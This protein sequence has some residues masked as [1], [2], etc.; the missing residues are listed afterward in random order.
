MA[1]LCY[2]R[3]RFPAE[4]IQHPLAGAE[5]VE[6]ITRTAKADAFGPRLRFVADSPLEG[7]GFEPSVPLEVLTVVIVPCRLRGPFHA[8]KF[9]ADSALEERFEPQVPP[10]GNEG[11]DILVVAGGVIPPKDYGFL[12]RPGSV[13]LRSRHLRFHRNQSEPNIRSVRIRVVLL[14][15][16]TAGEPG[17]PTVFWQGKARSNERYDRGSA[18]SGTVHRDYAGR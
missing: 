18:C 8:S 14:P 10:A 9:A 15:G 6:T 1:T 3:H 2:R 7:A 5:E 13:P 17:A 16:I 4:I 12:K 11:G